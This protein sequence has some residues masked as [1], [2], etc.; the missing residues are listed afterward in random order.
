LGIYY[1]KK[2]KKP[3]RTPFFIRFW[4]KR[5]NMA[6][7]MTG[8]FSG[9]KCTERLKEMGICIKRKRITRTE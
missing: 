2:T 1:K 7:K 9:N 5:R 8:V 3:E 6:Q 4:K